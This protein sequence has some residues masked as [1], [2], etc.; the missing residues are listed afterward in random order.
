MTMLIEEIIYSITR[1]HKTCLLALKDK[2]L[3]KYMLVI[4]RNNLKNIA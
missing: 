1:K 4:V 2:H 3:V